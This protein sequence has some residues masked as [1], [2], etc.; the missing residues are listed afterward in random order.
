MII[1]STIN[2]VQSFSP[3]RMLGDP[4]RIYASRLTSH[5]IQDKSTIKREINGA[6]GLASHQATSLRPKLPL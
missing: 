2:T 1:T 5:A 6:A 3:E 4:D